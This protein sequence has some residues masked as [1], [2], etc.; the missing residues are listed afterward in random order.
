MV[1]AVET[2]ADVGS[3]QDII[4]AAVGNASDSEVRKSAVAAA[5]ETADRGKRV[6]IAAEAVEHLPA[7]PQE[8]IASRFL[9]SEK[10]ADK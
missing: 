1:R 4:A 6:E 9:P 2:A 3:E 5:V 10:A 8:Q 7:R